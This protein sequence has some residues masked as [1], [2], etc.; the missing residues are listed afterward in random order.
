VDHIL[1]VLLG[2]H[3]LAA[4]VRI[5]FGV[6]VAG[7]LGKFDRGAHTA[8]LNRV[9]KGLNHGKG[10]AGIQWFSPRVVLVDEDRRSRRVV[11]VADRQNAFSVAVGVCRGPEPDHVGRERWRGRRRRRRSR[12]RHVGAGM[13]LHWI[14]VAVDVPPVACCIRALHGLV[15]D[16]IVYQASKPEIVAWAARVD[17]GT[18]DRV[19][20]LAR[21]AFVNFINVHI[22]RGRNPVMRVSTDRD[23]RAR[24]EIHKPGRWGRR[25]AAKMH[26][27]THVRASES[28]R[29]VAWANL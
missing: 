29:C 22:A 15:A 27:Q 17:Q 12:G 24:G 7:N 11:R 3:P 25:K 9:L 26:K 1:E 14:S 6:V 18:A 8:I 28:D 10:M 16:V 20:L 13:L 2:V 5:N 4:H 19:V 23:S 21:D